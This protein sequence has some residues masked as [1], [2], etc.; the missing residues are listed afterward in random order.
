MVQI[1]A[2]TRSGSQTTADV[3]QAARQV[4]GKDDFLKLLLT[5]L[6]YQ[7][8]TEPV[9]N[10]EFAAQ[11]AQFSALEQMQNLNT[12]VTQL[13]YLQEGMALLS[14][15]SSLL[16]REVEVYDPDRGGYLEGKVQG[17]LV[18]DSVPYLRILVN[19]NVEEHPV[20]NVTEVR[21]S[22]GA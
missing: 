20:L 6:E 2:T 15:A 22:E 5:Q 14:Q 11:L 12:A 21:L 10:E 3:T 18:K 9:K 7:D 4:M 1:S 17:V 19:G 8:P 13:I 16:G